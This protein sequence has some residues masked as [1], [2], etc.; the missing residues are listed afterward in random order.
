MH[1]LTWSSFAPHGE[2]FRVAR[3]HFI[4][5]RRPFVHHHDYAEVFW[6]E[7]NTGHHLI[8]GHRMPLVPGDLF[9]MRPTDTHDLCAH[10]QSGLRL[11]NI[12]FPMDTLNFLHERY[13]PKN[14]SFWGGDAETPSHYTLSPTTTRW[15]S[16]EADAL[17]REPRLRI[18]LERFLL[19][20]LHTLGVQ[21]QDSRLTEI[22]DWIR[23]ALE[24]IRQPK[25]FTK[26]TPAL[27]CLVG[28]SPEH[29]SRL[30][31]RWLNQTPT[32]IVTEA[33]LHYASG[34][35]TMTDRP[36]IDICLECGFDSLS[37]FY[38]LFKS[39]YRLSPR[40]YRF[41]R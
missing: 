17:A 18:H 38:K 27:A 23:T 8:N 25:H 34:Q 33:R 9:L 28:R 3:Q 21:P 12:S 13:F 2:A 16:A 19:N 37:H 30:T 15:L 31:R 39:R 20:L 5:K 1:L 6:I 32:E 41:Q 7:K 35:L 4:Q 11:V 26:G 40:Q 24:Q 14:V 36:I 29:V 22:P 10:H